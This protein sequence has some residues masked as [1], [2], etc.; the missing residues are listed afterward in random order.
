MKMQ[1]KDSA[2]ANSR[3][4]FNQVLFLAVN[5]HQLNLTR[6]GSYLLFPDRISSKKAVITQK[7]KEGEECFEWAVLGALHHENVDLHQE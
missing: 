4:V 7:N 3:F 2:L 5:F 1:V 6:G